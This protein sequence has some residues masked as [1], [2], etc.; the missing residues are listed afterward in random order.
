MTDQ[1]S[2]TGVEIR[3]VKQCGL[4]WYQVYVRGV[5]ACEAPSEKGARVCAR[6]FIRK[7]ARL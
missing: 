6:N 3:A 5:L 4:S 1:V 7:L 2:G